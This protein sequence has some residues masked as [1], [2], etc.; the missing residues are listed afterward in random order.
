M[1]LKISDY[2]ATSQRAPTADE[3]R[4]ALVEVLRAQKIPV[5]PDAKTHL[6]LELKD[7]EKRDEE[8]IKACARVRS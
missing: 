8:G 7:S 6:W 1:Q 3:I 4:E 5:S 2:R